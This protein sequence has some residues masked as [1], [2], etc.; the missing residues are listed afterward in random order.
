MYTK[1]KEDELDDIAQN[2]VWIITQDYEDGDVYIRHQLT[3]DSDNG[4]MYYEDSVGTNLDEISYAVN[5][6][7]FDF[8]GKRNATQDTVQEIY[9]SVF[10]VLFDRTKAEEEVIIGPALLGFSGL[11]VAIDAVYKDRV[12][13]DV[14]LELPLP[15]NSIVVTLKAFASFNEGEAIQAAAVAS[16]ASGRVY[17]VADV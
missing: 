11:T 9:N 16:D 6:I 1:F 14:S 3:T 2:G 10:S 7:L 15:L 12:N 8:I 5:S 4:N 13:V 17:D